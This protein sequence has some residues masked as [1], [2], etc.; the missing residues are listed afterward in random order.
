MTDIEIHKQAILA[1]DIREDRFAYVLD[2]YHDI[3]LHHERISESKD[4]VINE[5]WHGLNYLEKCNVGHLSRNL[6]AVDWGGKK[7]TFTIFRMAEIA[8]SLLGFEKEI[9]ESGLFDLGRALLSAFTYANI[10]A[11]ERCNESKDSPYIVVDIFGS[12]PA[13]T[14]PNKTRHEPFPPWKKNTDDFGNRLVR[15]CY[16][17]PQELQFVPEIQSDLQWV[18]A[19]RKL[20]TTGFQINKDMLNWVIENDQIETSRIIQKPED[21]SVF[22]NR[23][24][25]LKK[26]KNKDYKYWE[27]FHWLEK[28]ELR[29][30][31][32][33]SRFE[34]ELEY[35]KR[36]AESRKPF[37]HRVGLDYRGQ[38]YLP[39]F[40]YQGS[41]F[42][43]A[44]IEFAEHGTLNKQSY[45][46]LIRH[47]MDHEG[48]GDGL[49]ADEKYFFGIKRI[50]SWQKIGSNPHK[51]A[52]LEDL[53]KMEKPYC[54]LRSC[55]EWRD[56]EPAYKNDKIFDSHLP[57]SADHRNSA[58]QHI[59]LMVGTSDGT[60]LVEQ[61]LRSD[62]YNV[63]AQKTSLPTEEARRIV[64][65]IMLPWSYGGSELSFKDEIRD[66]Q[67]DHVGEIPYL[68]NL[69][70]NEFL[71][72]FIDV[73]EILKNE[74]EIVERYKEIV[75]TAVKKGSNRKDRAS[76]EGIE[77]QVNSQFIVNQSIFKTKEVEGVVANSFL[78]YVNL[79]VK[80]IKRPYEIDWKKMEDKAPSSLVHSQNA[81]TA[82]Q[83]ISRG[84]VSMSRRYAPELKHYNRLVTL[85][86]SFSVLIADARQSLDGL[87]LLTN[88][89]YVTDPLSQFESRVSGE[90]VKTRKRDLPDL[91]EI[92][93]Q[94]SY[95]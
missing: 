62:L 9:D 35:A 74:F 16:P 87:H 20:E 79:A 89:L 92:A 39:D 25:A 26:S 46:E 52:L 51:Y 47:T 4:Y 22:K 27:E 5:I 45:V 72:L 42:C 88:F 30:R 81:T 66:Y 28:F 17:C 71:K 58:L 85:H 60:S 77:W 83:L 32:R 2:N 67:L 34:R 86:D 36:L 61:C 54:F 18:D 70:E 37:Y 82:H 12:M 31:L 75:K 80:E 3:R 6:C 50:A 33:R 93:R 94:I 53:R 15:A 91:Y 29:L 48:A 90:E 55:F 56:Y 11:L 64:K 43:R 65:V 21:Y 8:A 69:N 78:N 44:V 1:L 38:L 19:V 76:L 7:A 59:G 13:N 40:S 73:C 24:E 68:D 49:D 14:L 23:K 84:T 41:D 57:I 63:I 95:N 10:Y